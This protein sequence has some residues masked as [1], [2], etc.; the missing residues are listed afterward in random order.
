M[1][2][3]IDGHK[4]D[5]DKALFVARYSVQ[6]DELKYSFTETL[7]YKKKGDFF[8]FRHGGDRDEEDFN[9]FY[10]VIRPE[11]IPLSFQEAKR[12]VEL[13]CSKFRFITLFGDENDKLP[14]KCSLSSE[15]LLFKRELTA[16]RYLNM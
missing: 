5:T 7:F 4:Y 2:K 15:A 11:I 14:N 13:H 8:V 16:L 6:A 12:W 3:L 1:K 9:K 10:W